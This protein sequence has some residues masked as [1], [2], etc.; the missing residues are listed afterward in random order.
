LA[1]GQKRAESVRRSLA[2]LGVKDN[3]MEAVSFGE[4]KPAE[5][6]E[7]EQIHGRNRRVEFSLR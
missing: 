2:L 6:G 3:Q 1:L 7:S 5:R 4:E